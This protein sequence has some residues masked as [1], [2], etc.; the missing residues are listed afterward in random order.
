MPCGKGFA[1][2][3]G[4]VLMILDAD[5]TVPPEE[6][7]KFYLGVAEGVAEFINGS[8]LVYPLEDEAMR[9]ANLVGNKAFSL[10]LHLVAWP[11]HQGYALWYQG[12][13]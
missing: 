6:L 4:D 2:A 9:F 10:D 13:A 11:A 3:K 8:R 12:P 5:L 7:P 1:A